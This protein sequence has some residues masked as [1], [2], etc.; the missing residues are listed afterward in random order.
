MNKTLLV[1]VIVILLLF[2]VP[3]AFGANTTSRNITTNSTAITLNSTKVSS[4][5]YAITLLHNLTAPVINLAK[6]AS[7]ILF[8]LF[9]VVGEILIYQK[10]ITKD[11]LNYKPFLEYFLLSLV[12]LVIPVVIGTYSTVMPGLLSGV[13]KSALTSGI[14]YETDAIMII[15]LLISFAGFFIFIKYLT[16]TLVDYTDD[17]K[18]EQ[19]KNKL[20]K[21]VLLFLFVMFSPYVFIILFLGLSKVLIDVNNSF[22]LSTSTLVTTSNLP[23][24]QMHPTAYSGCTSS[25]QF[26][27]VGELAICVG[28]SLT[29]TVGAINSP[30]TLQIGMYQAVIG[31]MTKGFDD[32]ALNQLIFSLMFGIV[33]VI[34]FAVLDYKVLKYLASIDTEKDQEALREIKA[35]LLQFT[36]FSLSPMLYIIFLIVIGSMITLI[37]ALLF[38]SSSS[39]DLT[40][41]PIPILFELEGVPTVLNPILFISGVL[42][43]VFLVILI[44]IVAIFS[45]TKIFA[46]GFFS[47]S[48]YWYFSDAPHVKAFGERSY[49]III[50]IFLMPIFL[51][52]FY[53]I[54]FGLI[55][56]M[57]HSSLFAGGTVVP[58]SS[59]GYSIKADGNNTATLSGPGISTIT[60]SCDNQQSLS[61]AV[62]SIK[63]NSTNSE[64]AYGAMLYSCQ[65]YV[66]GYAISVLLVDIVFVILLIVGIWLL[67]HG[68]FTSITSSFTGVT[69]SLKSGHF[70]EAFNKMSE[71]T[72]DL[73]NKANK[74]PFIQPFIK[75]PQGIYNYAKMPL[76]GTTE[77]AVLEGTVGTVGALTMAVPKTMLQ[78][79]EEREREKRLEQAMKDEYGKSHAESEE[80]YQK[81]K[82]KENQLRKQI[83]NPNLDKN[84]R[85]EL[86][87]QLNEIRGYNK[88][89]RSSGL[90]GG[91]EVK[92]MDDMLNNNNGQFMRTLSEWRSSKDDSKKRIGNMIFNSLDYKKK[93]LNEEYHKNP[94]NV[95]KLL[96]DPYYSDIYNEMK[97]NVNTREVAYERARNNNISIDSR[98]DREREFQKAQEIKSSY[99]DMNDALDEN[100]GDIIKIKNSKM[101]PEEKEE[102]IAKIKA[103][104]I[105]NFNKTK[106]ENDYD[107]ED[108][109]KIISGSKNLAENYN[110]I[111]DIKDKMDSAKKTVTNLKSKDDKEQAMHNISAISDDIDDFAIGFGYTNAQEFIDKAQNTPSY[112]IANI[113]SKINK[114]N[115]EEDKAMY[116][117]QMMK[118]LGEF[119][120]KENEI[121]SI[122][123]NDS[124]Q[125]ALAEAIEKITSD[126][127]TAT[128]EELGEM[129]KSSYKELANP[130][131]TKTLK[132]PKG[133]LSNTDENIK[134]MIA[135]PVNQTFREYYGAMRK[136]VNTTW[137]QLMSGSVDDFIGTLGEQSNYY[138]KQVSN[139]SSEIQ[140]NMTRLKTDK[141][142]SDQEKREIENNINKLRKKMIDAQ[143]EITINNK[144]ADLYTKIPILDSLL[145]SAKEWNVAQIGDVVSQYRIQDKMT[146]NQID[147][148]EKEIEETNKSLIEKKNKLKETKDSYVEA[149]LRI[150]IDKMN[151]NLLKLENDREYLYA[152]ENGLSTF[153]NTNDN[154]V[155]I[156]GI[157]NEANRINIMENLNNKFNNAIQKNDKLSKMIKKYDE[158]RTKYVQDNESQ[159]RFNLE[160]ETISKLLSE[161]KT[162]DD[163]SKI[164]LNDYN[165]LDDQTKGIINQRLE[166]IKKN[167][168]KR[169][170]NE[171][172]NSIKRTE[173]IKEILKEI[174]ANKEHIDELNKIKEEKYL[175]NESITTE[176][177]NIE[178][179]ERKIKEKLEQIKS[180]LNPNTENYKE[181]VDYLDDTEKE[182]FENIDENKIVDL[183]KN[184][185]RSDVINNLDLR[186]IAKEILSREIHRTIPKDYSKIL[187]TVKDNMKEELKQE[188]LENINLFNEKDRDIIKKELENSTRANIDDAVKKLAD[189]N[190]MAG[191]ILYPSF[192]KINK[193]DENNTK[194]INEIIGE[195]I[196]E[197]NSNLETMKDLINKTKDIISRVNQSEIN[198]KMDNSIPKAEK[199]NQQ[200][201]GK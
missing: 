162:P 38:T 126:Y 198:Y 181:I 201:K 170:E 93:L 14:A 46:S 83:E 40:F 128:N 97:E 26:W 42:G 69:T 94:N 108:T 166:A 158:G 20:G 103:D 11:N 155:T 174:E 106:E 9:F 143:T 151:A 90:T 175:K 37:V 4:S 136:M 19:A 187:E 109:I 200:I 179:G 10:E 145:Q 131:I 70:T 57:I 197:S 16:Q 49:Y 165:D 119:G 59:F 33:M 34:S 96:Q 78:K 180:E 92:F 185:I 58:G 39:S 47:L 148:I 117:N 102:K 23:F 107:G 196:I 152:R 17:L 86:Q 88:I 74:S 100:A 76:A 65:N 142:L 62:A 48:T 178:E 2:L 28:D 167:I 79:A 21:I 56:S 164:N 75:A 80:D 27:Q 183:V 169:V 24:L 115:T 111:K 160:L 163:V 5:S 15:A 199:I 147:T 45:L 184:D 60:Y 118:M 32:V 121:K 173:K 141:T 140:S 63:T 188:V 120:L 1:G 31:L 29:Y 150:Q 132:I 36:A 99:R 91:D 159:M 138:A 144:T 146:K 18:R 89:I 66:N 85:K 64:N 51:L 3:S 68:G 186:P 161:A 41:S 194:Y 124:I 44:V 22:N 193:L 113:V 189:S 7:Y 8:L 77:G 195:G 157:N 104:A 191:E 35:R 67:A 30:Y 95:V 43:L 156:D 129:I 13:G 149:S 98:E 137:D 110:S 176:K 81:R 71:G 130:L 101:K 50:A 25:P 114:S 122:E 73:L 154:G 54:F 133:I 61:N 190:I 6:L 182:N 116:K 127:S 171:K 105:N 139:Y 153:L 123:K 135:N 177:E 168:S 192:Q 12:I 82:E 53:S 125:P 52:F 87:N 134:A 112:K 55:P 72:G 172:A 84:K